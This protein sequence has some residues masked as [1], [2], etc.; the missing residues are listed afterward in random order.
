[1]IGG[2]A[3]CLKYYGEHPIAS[4]EL[5]CSQED[6][7]LPLPLNDQENN[8]YYTAFLA[9]DDGV[10]FFAVALGANDFD[11]EGNWVDRDGHQI[12]YSSWGLNEPDDTGDYAMMQL[13]GGVNNWKD[14]GG[15]VNS[16]GVICVSI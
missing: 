6:A 9:I 10:S 7:V 11:V 4:A 5:V 2:T 1:M 3:K 14:V 13:T 16:V 8:D 12:Q 15:F